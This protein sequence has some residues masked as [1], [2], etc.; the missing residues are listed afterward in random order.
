MNLK[1]QLKAGYF[2]GGTPWNE[3]PHLNINTL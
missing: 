3:I 1:Y 2:F